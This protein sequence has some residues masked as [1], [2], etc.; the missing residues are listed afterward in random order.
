MFYLS[1]RKAA[2]VLG[3][4]DFKDVSRWLKMFVVDGLLIV[5]EQ[6]GPS[7]NKATRY[8]WI[9][10]GEATSKIGMVVCI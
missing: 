2:E 3:T 9:A 4:E 8:R 6:G 7:T 5:T 1:C 10:K